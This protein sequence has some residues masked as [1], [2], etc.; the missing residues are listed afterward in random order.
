MYVSVRHIKTVDGF[1]GCYR[2]L[3]SKACGSILSAI[4]TQ[5]ITD[6]LEINKVEED[7]EDMDVELA[8]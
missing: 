2:G 6:Y 3:E 7:E 5:K 8:K 4:A 1:T